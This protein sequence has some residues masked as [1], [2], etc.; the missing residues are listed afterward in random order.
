[1]HAPFHRHTATRAFA[2]AALVAGGLV[3]ASA[4]P[5]AAASECS[6]V[7]AGSGKATPLRDAAGRTVATIWFHQR[8]SSPR[9]CYVLQA[10]LYRGTAHY[11]YLRICDSVTPLTGCTGWD[12][13]NYKY[14]A[15]PINTDPICNSAV[16]K[17][18][19][20]NGAVLFDRKI[21]GL[22]DICN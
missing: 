8:T 21:S 20:P 7:V 15:G 3:A 10:G 13:G 16:V 6:N 17:V 22:N 2:A 1:M 4:Q 11:M 12:A 18:H 19:A 5:A 9:G 14:F